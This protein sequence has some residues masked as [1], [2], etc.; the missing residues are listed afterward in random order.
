MNDPEY[1]LSLFK[2]GNDIVNMS[3]LEEEEKHRENGTDKSG[4]CAVFML[5]G[6]LLFILV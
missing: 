1:P 4:S 6:S 3:L 2:G 5:H